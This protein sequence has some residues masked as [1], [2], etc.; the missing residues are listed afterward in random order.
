MNIILAAVFL[1]AFLS[2]LL[3]IIVFIAVYFPSLQ[4]LLGGSIDIASYS[5][6]ALEISGLSA[7]IFAAWEFMKSRRKPSLQI[8]LQPVEGDKDKGLPT[9]ESDKSWVYSGISRR[10]GI[11][12][13]FKFR[14]LLGNGGDSIANYVKVVMTLGERSGKSVRGYTGLRFQRLSEEPA[15][16]HWVPSDSSENK[17]THVF[18]G[19]DDFIAYSQTGSIP[20]NK[21]LLDVL[22][23]FEIHVPAAMGDTSEIIQELDIRLYADGMKMK[24]E[25]LYLKVT[26]V[27]HHK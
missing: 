12:Y 13:G 3:S 1:I 20:Q 11:L 4:G 5:Q 25:K 19:G 14:L 22:G 15:T 9:K 24:K 21:D 17:K 27:E 16:G 26:G 8:W 10:K 23:T 7:L 6:V 18:H 2:L